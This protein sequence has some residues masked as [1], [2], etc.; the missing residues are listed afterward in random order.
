MIITLSREFGAG[1]SLIA[2]RIAET[3]G[4]KVVDNE[5]VGRIAE[6]AGLTPAEV[7]EREER[8]PGF[9]ERLLRML[10]KAAPEIFPAP[11]DQV[12]ELEEAKLVKITETV[13]EDVARE[14]RVVLVGRAAEV[15]L[16]QERDAL[17]VKIVA[18]RAYRVEQ[19]ANREGMARARAEVMVR[20]A[21][22]N[23]KRYHL[24]H[25][26]RD[27]SDAANYHVVLNV[28]LLGAESTVDLVVVQARRMWGAGVT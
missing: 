17:H 8:A 1:G 28:A 7:A 4:W 16:R 10:T 6:R 22:E 11:A 15:V 18:P 19:F 5:L 25:Y 24:Q 13:V 9:G 3:L 26:G 20:E 2:S 27:W 12:P 14:G 21:D 23:R